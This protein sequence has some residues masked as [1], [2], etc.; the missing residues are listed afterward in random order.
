MIAKMLICPAF[1]LLSLVTAAAPAYADPNPSNTEPNPF[2]GLQCNCQQ[3][4]APG[5]NA[6]EI[7]RGIR[8]ALSRV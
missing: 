4:V 7:D 8:T 1:A 3:T 6:A 5:P 2:A